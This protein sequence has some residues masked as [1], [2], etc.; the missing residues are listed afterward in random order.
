MA[1]EGADPP[2]VRARGAAT[3]NRGHLGPSL[4]GSSRTFRRGP[5]RAAGRRRCLH[6]LPRAGSSSHPRRRV[7]WSVSWR[8]VGIAGAAVLLLAGG[9]ALRAASAAPG[10]PVALPGPG[11]GRYADARRRP[12]ATRRL[13]VVD[14]VGAV[15]R[16]GRRAAA[17]RF[18]RRRRGRGRRRPDAR[19]R[20]SAR[21]TW[22]GSWSTASRS[23]CRSRGRTPRS[24]VPPQEPSDD[25][26]D[27]NTADVG[28]SRRAAR[29][30]AGPRAA[31]RGASRRRAV[32]VGRRSRRRERHRTHP[33]RPPARPGARVTTPVLDVDPAIEASRRPRSARHR[34]PPPRRA[35]GRRLARGARGRARGAGVAAL[36]AAA[37]VVVA[38]RGRCGRPRAGSRPGRVARCAARGPGRVRSEACRDR[39]VGSRSATAW[40]ASGPALALALLAVGA[41]LGA[42]ASQTSARAHGL[43]PELAATRSTGTLTGRVVGEPALL[44][45]AWPGAPPRA[46]CIVA[47][48]SA[49]GHGRTSAAVGQVLVIGPPSLAYVPYGARVRVA[50]RL[51]VGA[52]GDRVV[53]VLLTSADPEVVSDPAALGRGRHGRPGGRRRARR[54]A[55]RRRRRSAARRDGRRHERRV[56]RPRGGHACRRV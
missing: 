17:G 6:R 30:R 15:G 37:C 56:E 43:L 45:P 31:D 34:R 49:A 11:A 35:G 21:S 3:R 42:G 40:P 46:R 4:P 33:A 24:A 27:L 39:S 2:V 52:P 25:R 53:A 47:V 51:Q 23:S 28:R 12:P 20:R 7:R 38:V 18:A 22:P 19:T 48:D 8:L 54:P 14:V 9:V 26:V 44:A 32:H 50:G 36:G 29:H 1:G 5:G 10:A 41:V 13:V 16:A 55:A